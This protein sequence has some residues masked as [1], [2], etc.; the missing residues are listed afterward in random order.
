M[1]HQLDV[2]KR[3]EQDTIRLS[4]SGSVC[5][6]YGGGA[7]VPVSYTHLYGAVGDESPL[8]PRRGIDFVSRLRREEPPIVL[9]LI[10]IS[11]FEPTT[12]CE[13]NVQPT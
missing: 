10:H 3:Q 8:F 13:W 1:P 12:S 7:S 2:Y 11:I 4:G 9:S 6:G 5:P